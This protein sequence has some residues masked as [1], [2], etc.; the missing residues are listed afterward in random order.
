LLLTGR[1][2]WMVATLA[3]SQATGAQI[4]P[5]PVSIL[6][7]AGV[8]FSGSQP[9]PSDDGRFVLFL[10]ADNVTESRC[11][12]W[13]LRDLRAGTTER[14]SRNLSGGPATCTAGLTSTHTNSADIS[15]DGSIV[16]FDFRA[17]DIHPAETAGRLRT[18]RLDRRTGRMDLLFPERPGWLGDGVPRM[19]ASGTRILVQTGYAAGDVRASV[20]DERGTPVLEIAN[21]FV[22]A[23]RWDLSADGRFIVLG[24]QF[25]EL[26]LGQRA[27]VRKSVDTGEEVIV[28]SNA[29]R[30]ADS[31]VTQPTISADGSLG[32]FTSFAP[33]LTPG[34]PGPHILMWRDG[35]ADLEIISRNSEGNPS[36][37]ATVQDLPSMSA[38]GRYVAFRSRASNFPG[39]RDAFPS[40]PQVYV[41]DRVAGRLTLI[42]RTQSGAGA[43]WGA[44]D[45]NCEQAGPGA[46]QCSLQLAPRMAADGSAVFFHSSSSDLHPADPNWPFGFRYPR[47]FRFDYASLIG[48][49]VPRAV[50]LSGF[51]IISAFMLVLAAGLLWHRRLPTRMP[52]E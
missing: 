37:A 19:D 6:P 52:G 24:I 45:G 12:Q 13:Y 43:A 23:L 32:A 26:P 3:L 31:M 34:I 22:A 30:L 17:V 7:S 33:S 11:E 36:I 48:N 8:A 44:S 20:V 2:E 38:D 25:P 49:D 40:Y 41:R 18:Y 21:R 51:A 1:L 29:G 5:E 42:S 47:A 28:S 35:A 4:V 27:Q 46:L 39:G 15:A 10:G 50:P 16:V 9:I 14:V